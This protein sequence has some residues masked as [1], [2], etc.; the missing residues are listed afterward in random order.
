M[1]DALAATLAITNQ[2][3]GQLV[4]ILTKLEHSQRET[5]IRSDSFSNKLELLVIETGNVG[6][7]LHEIVESLPE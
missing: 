2:R 5:L 7:Q 3:L 6:R 4:E 1:S